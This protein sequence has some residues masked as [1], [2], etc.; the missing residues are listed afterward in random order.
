M[1]RN[2]VEKDIWGN[3]HTARCLST[4]SNYECNLSGETGDIPVIWGPQGQLFGL[5]SDFGDG[6][7]FSSTERKNHFL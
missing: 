3:T 1:Q 2:G 6:V 5:A 4:C 7:G